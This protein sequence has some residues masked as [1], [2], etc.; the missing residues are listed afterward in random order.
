[1][2]F[3]EVTYGICEQCGQRDADQN[4]SNIT[5]ADS[6]PT[7]LTGTGTKLEK[8]EGR[9]LCPLCIADAKAI[10]DTAKV[11]RKIA[12]DEKF[13]GQA[14]FTNTPSDGNFDY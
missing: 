4:D 14:G 5:D 6:T 10:R 1:M 8:F 3:P 7:E 12:A 2:S 13:R 11:A 9:W